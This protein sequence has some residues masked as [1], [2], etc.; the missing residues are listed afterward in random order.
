MPAAAETLPVTATQI[1]TCLWFDR[2]MGA[3]MT[4]TEIDLAAIKRAYRG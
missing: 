2:V 1:T 3:V 4:M